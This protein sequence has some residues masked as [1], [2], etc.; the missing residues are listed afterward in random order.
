MNTSSSFGEP[1]E[2]FA[3]LQSAQTTA[4]AQ[5]DRFNGQMAVVKALAA[6]TEE[7]SRLQELG[8]VSLILH[9]VHTLL[10]GA[11]EPAPE[12][13]AAPAEAAPTLSSVFDEFSA[14]LQASRARTQEVE[15]LLTQSGWQLD[16]L[17]AALV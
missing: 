17:Q 15:V 8:A 9:R 5:I 6:Q 7:P 14:L 16:H 13:V 12:A 1:G 3:A 4:Q 10:F 11:A 2:L